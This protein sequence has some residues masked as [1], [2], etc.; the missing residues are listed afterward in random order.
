MILVSL[1]NE[2]YQS[3]HVINAP[4]QLM[5]GNIGHIQLMIYCRLKHYIDSYIDSQLM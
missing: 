2:H 3:A 5:H 1:R 4:W